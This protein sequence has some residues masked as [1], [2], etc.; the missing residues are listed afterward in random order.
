MSKSIDQPLYVLKAK[1]LDREKDPVPRV[2]LAQS[3]FRH[4]RTRWHYLRDMIRDKDVEVRKIQT[5]D[6]IADFFTKPIF[7]EKLQKFTAQLLG[8]APRD[9]N[10]GEKLDM[11]YQP[12]W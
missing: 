6:Q 3:K 12:I 5:D 8:H 7:G 1:V 9:H 4:L 10:E 2:P 11:D